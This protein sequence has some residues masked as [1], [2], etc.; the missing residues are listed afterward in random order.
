MST[1]ASTGLTDE[2][3]SLFERLESR[4]EG[5]DIGQI[6]SAFL[7]SDSREEAN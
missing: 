5:E 2:E 1:D 4:F 7:Q 6:A 3:R